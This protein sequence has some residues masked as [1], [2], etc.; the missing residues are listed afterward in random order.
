MLRK[1]FSL[2]SALALIATM[3]FSVSA[4]EFDTI[5]DDGPIIEEYSYTSSATIG[6]GIVNKQATC[7]CSLIGYSGT[8]TK[9]TVTQTLQRKDGNSWY[10]V[11]SW[12]DTFYNWYCNFA[13]TTTLP[14][15]TYRHKTVFKVYSGSSYETITLYSVEDSC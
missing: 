7:D 4:N 11:T 9:I 12:S 15:G 8:T 1:V 5:I 14:S 6:F 2:V 10:D 3:S 13:N